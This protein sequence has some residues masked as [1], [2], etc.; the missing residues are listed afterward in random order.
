[1]KKL[2]FF[3][4]V[5]ICT[6]NLGLAGQASAQS[7]LDNIKKTATQ[8]TRA[9]QKSLQGSS[10]SKMLNGSIGSSSLSEKDLIGTWKY[11]GSNCAFS[12][13]NML[14]K[15]G[16]EMAAQKIESNLTPIYKKAGLSSANTY[17]TLG[18]DKKFSAKV[19]G[20][21]ITGSYSFDA[22]NNKITFQAP[23]LHSTCYVTK[24]GSNLNFLFDSS[25]LLTLLQTVSAVSDNSTLQTLGTLSKNYDGAKM[26]FALKK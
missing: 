19:A 18:K 10:I 26:G 22:K 8:A 14:A 5:A 2:R 11:A 9:T 23:L 21:S 7:L 20:K 17:F 25:K 16:G 15:A 1:M 13:Q 3:T 24:S 6:M 12:S 4:I